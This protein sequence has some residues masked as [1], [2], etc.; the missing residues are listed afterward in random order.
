MAKFVDSAHAPGAAESSRWRARYLLALRR[1]ASTPRGAFGLVALAVV[2]FAAVFGQA[3][4][5]QSAT[6][7]NFNEI[8]APPS[9]AHVFG[10]DDLGR[11]LFTRTI[12]GARVSLLVGLCSVG[13]AVVAGVPIGIAAGY[14]RGTFDEVSMRVLDGLLAFPALI[15][16][17]A[18][19]AALGA[20]PRNVVIAIGIVT[21]PTFARLA[22]GQA[23]SLREQDM[24]VAARAVGLRDGRILSRYVLP[25]VASVLI[26]QGALS[27]GQAI[28]TEAGL[29]FLG[30]GIRPPI[31]SWGSMIEVGRG[32]LEQAPWMSVVPGV[33]ILLTVFAF[34][35]TGDALLDA[36]DPRL[37]KRG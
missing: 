8:L 7:Q 12:Y 37:Q 1:L 18:I 3:L 23:L 2:L 13:L 25:N 35:F 5:P 30:L 22:R 26:I 14:Y 15:L 33:A 34:N 27:T 10:T 36:L 19:A 29:S 32:Y 21:V 9:S 6:I 11:D 20:G 16:A 31:P 24:I 4:A 28:L 17:I